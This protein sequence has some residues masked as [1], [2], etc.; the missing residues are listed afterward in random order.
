[1]TCLPMR[2][3]YASA[4][5]RQRRRGSWRAMP[6]TLSAWPIS[7]RV[8]DGAAGERL[9]SQLWLLTAMARAGPLDRATTISSA[10]RQILTE[11]EQSRVGVGDNGFAGPRL[12]L[13]SK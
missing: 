10:F 4:R 9:L 2:C 8:P 6:S 11:P 1:M 12:R 13:A 5:G 7:A 3:A